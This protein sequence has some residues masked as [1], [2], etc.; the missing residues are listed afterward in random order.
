MRSI[1]CEYIGEK[2]VGRG[3][4]WW[5]SSLVVGEVLRDGYG[6]CGGGEEEGGEE[7]EEG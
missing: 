2:F 1:P 4:D 7:G 3:L 5:D 6:C